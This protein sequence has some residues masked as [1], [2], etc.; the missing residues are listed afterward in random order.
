M[1]YYLL[2]EKKSFFSARLPVTEVAVLSVILR[3][4]STWMTGHPRAASI[5]ASDSCSNQTIRPRQEE[6]LVKRIFILLD[7]RVYKYTIVLS[8][9]ENIIKIKPEKSF[10]WY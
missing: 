4:T 1:K 8:N 2:R 9:G 3:C 10:L 7:S 5:A 6:H